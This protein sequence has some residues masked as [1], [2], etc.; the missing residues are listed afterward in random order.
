MSEEDITIVKEDILLLNGMQTFKRP[1]PISSATHTRPKT[2]TELRSLEKQL[3]DVE[4]LLKEEPFQRPSTAIQ[5]ARLSFLSSAVATINYYT[6]S[7]LLD[8]AIVQSPSIKFWQQVEASYFNIALHEIEDSPFH[9]YNYALKAATRIFSVETIQVRK[10]VSEVG[11]GL[12]VS[13]QTSPSLF[14]TAKKRIELKIKK[15]QQSRLRLASYAGLLSRFAILQNED[16]PPTLDEIGLCLTAVKNVLERIFTSPS[17]EDS[18][19]SYY[20][21]AQETEELEISIRTHKSNIST[22]GLFKTSIKAL[23]S[24]KKLP[25][26]LRSSYEGLFIP[27][28]IRRLWLPVTS[29]AIL[30]LFIRRSFSLSEVVS[31]YH[32]TI[33]TASVFV[34]EWL[35]RPIRDIYETIRHRERKLALLGTESLN[36]DLE[37]LQRMVVDFAKDHGSLASGTKSIDSLLESVQ[38]GDLTVVLEKYEEDIK[39]PLRKALSGDLIR[40]VLIQVQKGKVDMELAMTALDKL[41]RANE[42]IEQTLITHRLQGKDIEREDEANTGPLESGLMLCEIAVLYKVAM[43]LRPSEEKSALLNDLEDL[44]NPKSPVWV[45]KEAVKRMKESLLFLAVTEK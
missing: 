32:E 2:V 9:L 6:V 10:S 20:Q 40:S 27:S 14:D 37:S 23:R 3:F 4:T 13:L 18:S 35:L 24:V 45:K 8:A 42:N 33:K 12:A 36:S 26:F 30:A 22:K 39:F 38:R 19:K 7:F 1:H 15:L 44:S 28:P 29:A 17:L 43:S 16:Q 25:S 5:A 41:L 11:L 21:V 34:S 31:L